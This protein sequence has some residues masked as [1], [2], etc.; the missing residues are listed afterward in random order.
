MSVILVF[1]EIMLRFSLEGSVISEKP[2]AWD[3]GL[4][5]ADELKVPGF[6]SSSRILSVEGCEPFEDS[7]RARILTH[8]R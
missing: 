3:A 1:P 8:L 2:S 7:V 5:T 6:S 4:I